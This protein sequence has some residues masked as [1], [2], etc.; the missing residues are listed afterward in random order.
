VTDFCTQLIFM[1]TN[2]NTI[3]INLF[4]SFIYSA[5]SPRLGTLY[6]FL[7][8]AYIYITSNLWLDVFRISTISSYR[9]CIRAP[10]SFWHAWFGGW[11]P[12]PLDS[13]LP[14]ERCHPWLGIEPATVHVSTDAIVYSATPSLANAIMSCLGHH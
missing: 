2:N 1:S 4:Y 13:C 3:P 8:L 14:K 11:H 6:L 5:F 9:N 12:L 7:S 10:I